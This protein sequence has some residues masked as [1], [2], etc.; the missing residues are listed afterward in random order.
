MNGKLNELEVSQL[1]LASG[2]TLELLSKRERE[3]FSAVVMGFS[4]Q[5]IGNAHH[6]SKHTVDT[7]RRNII[8]KT[9]FNS[10]VDWIRAANA[11]H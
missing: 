11:C 1:D 5:E 8:Q 2:T 7:H 10:L 6:I 9:G 4:S 3:I